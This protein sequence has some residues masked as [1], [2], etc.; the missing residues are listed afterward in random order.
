MRI[1]ILKIVQERAGNTFKLVA[2]CNDF[3]N[4]TQMA[5]QLREII[6]KEDYMNQK[7]SAQQNE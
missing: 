2:I 5:Q 3:L 1:E 7:A 4:R 6:D